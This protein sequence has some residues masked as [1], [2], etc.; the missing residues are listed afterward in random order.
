M[1]LGAWLW[2]HDG[3]VTLGQLAVFTG[4]L[5]AAAPTLRAGYGELPR[6][7]RWALPVLAVVAAGLCLWPLPTLERFSALGHEATYLD[8]FTGASPPG[9]EFGW[10][11]YVTYPLVR[12]IYWALGGVFGRDGFL[13]PLLF[14]VVCRGLGVFVGGWLAAV[15]VRK[16]A[17]GIAAAGLLAAHSVHAFWG[18]ALYNVALP[19]LLVQGCVLLALLAW[20]TGSVATF[21][22][23]AATGSLVV[24]GRVEW[25]LLA[26]C[27]AVLLAGLGPRWGRHGSVARPAFWLAPLGIAGAFAVTLFLGEGQLT[28]QGGYHGVAGYLETIAHQAGILAVFEPLDRPWGLAAAVFGAWAWGRAEGGRVVAAVLGFGLLSH[29]GLA[30]FNDYS[31]RHALLPGLGLVW[32]LAG[33]LHHRAGGLA[34]G[35]GVLAGLLGLGTTADRYY[36]SPEEFE[37]GYEGFARNAEVSAAEVEASGCYLITDNERLWEMGLAGSHFNLMIPGEAVKR[38]RHHGC[39]TWLYDAPNW[40]HDGLAVRVRGVKLRHWFDWEEIGWTRFE[41]DTPAVLMR[42]TSPPW[43]VEAGDPVPATDILMPWEVEEEP[44]PE[45]AVDPG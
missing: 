3:L 1:S 17:A 12:W 22:A 19:H 29:L 31:F 10:E 36:A 18:A 24:A 21:C 26:P 44:P 2:H 9:N 7:V 27:L 20:R 45:E 38:W 32:L 5:L 6:A 34:V 39:I 42:M 15:L 16:P 41:D 14:N 8:C 25:G 11:A 23:A 40:R 13:P 43:G 35:A 4:A 33:A 28:E 37:A 30:T